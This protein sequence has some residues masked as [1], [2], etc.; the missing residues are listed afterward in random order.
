M[1]VTQN[2]IR[3][4]VIL[5]KK[6]KIV[7]YWWFGTTFCSGFTLEIFSRILRFQ[8]N[9]GCLQP[10]VEGHWLTDFFFPGV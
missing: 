10:W 3:L 1:A 2:S 9:E 6:K 7:S 8:I 5:K 4:L